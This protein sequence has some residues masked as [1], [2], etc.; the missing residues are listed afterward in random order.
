[1]PAMTV[2]TSEHTSPWRS[3]FEEVRKAAGNKRD[4]HGIQGSINW[5]RKQM[6]LRGANPNV[7]RNIIYRD[8][9]R[10][11]DKRVLYEVLSALWASTGNGKLHNPEIELLLS[12]AGEAENELARLLG[13]EKKKA[14]SLFVGGVR[15]GKFPKL[16]LTGKPGSG[17]SLLID[18]IQ[19]A[20][21]VEPREVGR[22]VRM[23]FGSGRLETSLVRLAVAVGL[24]AE[25]VEAKIMKI[26]ASGAFSVQADAQAN[27]ARSILD[28]VRTSGE[29]LVL[30]THVSRSSAL[31]EELGETPLRLNTPD[32]P[33]VNGAEWLWL[34]LFGPLSRMGNVAILVSMADTPARAVPALA[35]FDESVRLSLPT[36]AEA[37]RFIRA[38]LPDLDE[39]EQENL[40]RTTGRSFEELRT[41]TLLHSVRRESRGEGIEEPSAERGD[42]NLR[43]LAELV[44]GSGDQRLRDFLSAVAVISLPEFPTISLPALNFVREGSDEPNALELAFLDALPPDPNRYRPFSRRFVRLLNEVLASEEPER[45]REFHARAASFYRS[46]AQLDTVS[47]DASRYIEHLFG[48]RDW[49][50]LIEWIRQGGERGSFIPQVWS[51]AVEELQGGEVFERVAHRVAHHYVRLGAVDHPQARSAFAAL[52]ESANEKLRSWS[53]LQQAEG[54]VLRGQVELAE[55]LLERISPAGSRAYQ[56]ELALV[57]ASI[58]RWRSELD[59]AA[60]FVD[61]GARP[62]LGSVQDDNPVAIG[63]KTSVWAGLIAKDRGDLEKALEEFSSVEVEDDLIEARVAF[64]K[65]DV[66]MSLGRFDAALTEL[67]NA[68]RLARQSHAL[69]SEQTRYLSRRGTLYRRLGELQLAREDF[70]AAKRILETTSSE[71]G[72]GIEREFWEARSE[73][74]WSLQL[75]AEGRFEDAILTLERNVVTFERYGRQLGV[76]PNYRVLRG[77]LRLARA[78]LSR[79]LGMPYRQPLTHSV[80]EVLHTADLQHARDLLTRVRAELREHAGNRLF[81]FLHRESLHLASLLDADPVRSQEFA[82]EAAALGRCPYQQAESQAHLASA[83]LRSGD[84]DG[85]KGVIEGAQAIIATLLGAGERSD[86]GLRS[87][88][89]ALQIE[90]ELAAGDLQAGAAVLRDVLADSSFSQ[91]HRPLLWIFGN[92]V[93]RGEPGDQELPA[94]LSRQLGYDAP[95]YPSRVRLPDALC[96][97]WDAR[98][99]APLPAASATGHGNTQEDDSALLVS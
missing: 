83:L 3:L 68:V 56:A 18:Y 49:E 30:L 22:V 76:D 41:L 60:I 42:Q 72:A 45:L 10:L 88:L 78:Y 57:R 32:V 33:R 27:V 8:K 81:W 47:E 75:L 13:R 51:A 82:R 17:K 35:T 7:V 4:E 34:S 53:L 21:E 20:L 6:E 55:E 52:E 95:V 90:T 43:Q 38:R 14:F 99:G 26:G 97:W 2:P 69:T 48:A 77:S 58:A 46:T 16:L 98:G 67:D 12:Q 44:T 63:T 29:P 65:G 73:N 87:Y 40:V 94:V 11:K 1:M 61:R 23:E 79:A 59:Q 28:A 37:R 15:A 84:L 64:Q 89:Y 86:L 25:Q 39:K 24:P 70:S 96:G 9:G 54:A 19:E 5:L 66:L 92:A 71:E 80:T 50:Q 85:A 31:V 62:M 91:F 36:L 93:Q 74:E